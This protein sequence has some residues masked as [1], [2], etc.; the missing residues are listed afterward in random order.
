MVNDVSK[1]RMFNV[2]YFRGLSTD[3]K[4]TNVDNGAEFLEIDTGDIYYYNAAGAAWV[5]GG[6]MYIRPTD[7]QAET[8]IGEWLDDHPEATTTVQDGAITT[9]KLADGAVTYKK[10]SSG[11]ITDPQL[12]SV[13][14]DHW[15]N[16]GFNTPDGT[17][18][19]NPGYIRNST[20]F[21]IS[22]GTVR[23]TCD[24]NYLMLL[25]A[26]DLE[27]NFVGAMKTD[28]TFSKTLSGWAKASTV[29]CAL[30]PNY[31]LKATVCRDPSN[32]AITGAEGTHFHC[33]NLTDKALT[34]ANKAAD[35]KA[36]GDTITALR[37]DVEEIEDIT[38]HV[39][40]NLLNFDDANFVTGKYIT[41]AGV[42]STNAQYNTSGYI[43]VEEGQT[44][45]YIYGDQLS[46]GREM[47]FL[48]AYDAAKNV[49]SAAGAT[50]AY[51]YT[52]PVGVVY[53]RFSAIAQ[54][55]NAAQSAMFIKGSSVD[56]YYAYFAP[57]TT[58]GLKNAAI[59]TDYIDQLIDAKMVGVITD[60][61]LYVQ[62]TDDSLTSTETLTVV[63]RIDNKKNAVIEF[64]GYFDSF[65]SLTL[66]HGYNVG[67]GSYAVIDDT[68]VTVY[69]GTT[70]TQMA[71]AAHGLTIAD[72]I[73]VVI[74]QNDGARAKIHIMS[75]GG[76]YT[77]TDCSWQ[78]CNGNVFAKVGATMTDVVCSA[79]FKDFAEQIF[80][81]GDS[82]VSMG[83]PARY[84]YY[85][86]QDGYTHLL[87]DG[88]GGR[89]S[90]DALT[91]FNNIV[92]KVSPKYAIWTLGMNDPDSTAV[93]ATWLSSVQSFLSTCATKG[94]TPILATVP[95]CPS[96]NN[97]YK[98][99][100]V[101]ASEYRYIDFAKAVGAEE[102]ESSWY[103][104]MLYTDNAHPTE[105]GAKALYSRFLTDFPEVIK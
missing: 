63:Q 96:V 81:F 98:N 27:G 83:D 78:G 40:P 94:I 12:V 58:Y 76:D 103:S 10:M 43:P 11:A 26:W 67:Y 13:T 52:V 15:V 19:D 56:K 97:T 70:P 69:Y 41:T 65:T 64:M 32:N 48:C 101:K 28:G 59:D 57:Y 72:F 33:L 5:V 95:N 47:R 79:V 68:N 104:G 87:I 55:M 16:G 9:A 61:G 2:S 93:N 30:Y 74:T 82:Y 51:S 100:W 36:T 84:P 25:F 102:A 99:A 105:L 24:A 6:S 18:I 85:L 66:G 14:L 29:D 45:T 44:Y 92:A 88:Y 31:L 50:S 34:K 23:V 22:T 73:H 91:S 62:A 38:N 77:L 37:N 1:G 7:E 17:A 4:P 21:G 42:L 35:A 86:V 53:I 80:L 49:V 54:Y 8:Y 89:G 60:K 90:A 20:P 71:Q 3:T 75:S 46:T 39:S